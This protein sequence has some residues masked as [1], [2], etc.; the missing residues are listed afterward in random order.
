MAARL[1]FPRRSSTGHRGVPARRV[2]SFVGPN[3]RANCHLACVGHAR[4]VMLYRL[5]GTPRCLLMI[6]RE[7]QSRC[8]ACGVGPTCESQLYD[9]K[10][11]D[12]VTILTATL[13]LCST[14]L[15]AALFP[16]T[17]L[18]RE[19]Y[20]CASIRV[21]NGNMIR[22]PKH[23]ADGTNSPSASPAALKHAPLTRL[24]QSF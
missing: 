5:A 19:P 4:Q 20:R 22:L 3:A 6:A 12:P 14:A 8:H 23:Q 11:T 17:R 2:M 13:V 10:P 16:P 15:G 1:R 24:D 18:G 21:V 7:P 9:V